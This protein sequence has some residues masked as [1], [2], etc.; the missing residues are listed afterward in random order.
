MDYFYV[1]N[2]FGS[3]GLSDAFVVVKYNPSKFRLSGWAHSFYSTNDVTDTSGSGKL[4]NGLGIEVDLV[5]GFKLAE[6]VNFAAGYS[7]M[8]ATA[9]MEAIKGGSKDATSN[10]AWFMIT[11]KPKF[12]SSE[13]KDD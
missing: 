4:S 9:T 13:D 2:H 10:W 8:F 12:F 7:Q 11:L 5:A 3:V 1:G 6:G